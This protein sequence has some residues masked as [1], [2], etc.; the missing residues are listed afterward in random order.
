VI[1]TYIMLSP[2]E[3]HGVSDERNLNDKKE[4]V[5][6]SEEKEASRKQGDGDN[7]NI[8]SLA[9][10]RK[11]SYFLQLQNMLSIKN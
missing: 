8:N 7:H 9:P 1:G 11:M 4:E 2:N 10:I 5:S 6:L 3:N